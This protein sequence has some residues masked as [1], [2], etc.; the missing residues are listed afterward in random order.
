MDGLD[1]LKAFTKEAD[2]SVLLSC[3]E[4]A[5]AA[6]LARRYP[7]GDWPQRTVEVEIPPVTELD[8]DTGEAV[9]VQPGRIQLCTETYLEPRYLD[10]QYRCALAI[11]EKRGG[12]FEKR[13]TE[14]N[15]TR[16]WGS[17]HI[18]SDLLEEVTPLCALVR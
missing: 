14:N 17:E 12:D 3:M 5:K 9:V 15:V 6:I 18:P 4:S 2:E 10:L 11:Y 13:H 7:F 16:E 1:R 8:P